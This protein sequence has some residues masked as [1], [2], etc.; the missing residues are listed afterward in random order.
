MRMNETEATRDRLLRTAQRLFARHG[1][2]GASVR[3]ITEEAG[4]NL[5]AITYHFGS[6]DALYQAVLSQLIDP[7]LQRATAAVSEDAPPLDRVESLMRAIFDHMLSNADVPC[8]MMH[9]MT[10]AGQFPA[11]GRRAQLEVRGML[12]ALVKEGQK[13]GSIRKGDPSLLALSVVAQ[14]IYFALAWRPLAEV[15]G[16]DLSDGSVRTNLVAHAI[17]FARRGLAPGI[18]GG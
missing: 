2:R 18:T 13:D 1:Y 12:E 10:M 11:P 15:H 4:T 5:G 8:L 9:Q 16:V 17:D 6:K 3:R 14:P 7:L